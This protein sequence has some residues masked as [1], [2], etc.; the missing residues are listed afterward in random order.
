MIHQSDQPIRKYD[1]WLAD[2]PAVPESH[3]QS[4][5]RPVIVVS[6]DVANAHSPIISIVP[7][8]TNL[9]RVDMPTHTVLHSRFLRRPS[10]ALC[11]QI[12][13]I[14]T[15]WLLNRMGALECVHERLAVRH[16][17]QVQ[18]GLAA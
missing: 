17:V 7:L 2:L 4:G 11:E 13:T 6:N 15:S 16:C 8:T 5:V 12:M 3:V 10:L 9:S 14:D 1:I 18:L